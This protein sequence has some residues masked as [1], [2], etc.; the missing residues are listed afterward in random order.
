MI[1]FLICVYLIIGIGF[2]LFFRLF[3][4]AL[5]NE[6]LITKIL[7]VIMWLPVFIYNLFTI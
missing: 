1:T 7:F 5:E 6:K 2:Y 4:K 3:T